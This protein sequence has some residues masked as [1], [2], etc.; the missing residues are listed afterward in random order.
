MNY[1]IFPELKHCILC[2]RN[3]GADRY[4]KKLGY[5]NADP[6][7]GISSICIHRG[8]EPAISGDRGICNIFFGHCNLRCLYCQN[9]Q[10][11][12]RHT[13][14][15]GYGYDIEPVIRDITRILDMGI[16][17]VGF[18]SPSHFLPHV[19]AIIAEL[20][21]R[22]YHPIFVY[23][24]NAYD[25]VE[26]LRKLEGLIDVYLPDFKYADA[27]LAKEYSDAVDYPDIA[28]KAIVEMY[29]QVGSTL[30]PG[31]AGVAE[32]GLIIRHLVLPGHIQNSL[33][34]LEMIAE[35]ISPNVHISLMSQ[36]YPTPRVCD[37]Q[38]LGRTLSVNEYGK[39]VR[40]ME[41]LGMNKGWIQELSSYHTYRPD[42]KN[43]RPFGD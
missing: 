1:E 13:Y 29:H 10:I 37:H 4:S 20:K 34:V 19:K 17:N 30:I 18:V 26:E 7:Y 14:I 21:V 42:F 15:P 33:D 25:K 28:Q 36:Y 40:K 38:N 11:S 9:Y 24:T 2:P 22:D 23:N 5:C 3:C 27:V 35:H 32:R 43:V 8:E 31:P 16:V 6:S 41:F 39:V 12:D